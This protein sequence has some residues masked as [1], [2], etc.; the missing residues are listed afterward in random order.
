M[1]AAQ[2][3]PKL[4]LGFGPHKPLRFAPVVLTVFLAKRPAAS[5]F[6]PAYLHAYPFAQVVNPFP[7][8]R[9]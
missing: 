2:P 4:S 6:T 3:H 9:P 5:A 1:R 8:H 7:D